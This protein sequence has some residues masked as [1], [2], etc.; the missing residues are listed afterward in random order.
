MSV[1]NYFS[2]SFNSLVHSFLTL[3]SKIYVALIRIHKQYAII[4][5]HV[6]FPKKMNKY[7]VL[8]VIDKLQQVSFDFEKECSSLFK[9]LQSL[10]SFVLRALFL[11]VEQI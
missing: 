11:D 1:I 9:R 3:D 6:Y 2:L 10:V 4:V 8:D 5:E 7:F